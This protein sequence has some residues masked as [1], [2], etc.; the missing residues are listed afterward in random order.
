M[1]A[2]IDPLVAIG[3]EI[4]KQK[5]AADAALARATDAEIKARSQDTKLQ[6]AATDKDGV[7]VTFTPL[8]EDTDFTAEAIQK[9]SA[10]AAEAR[11][12]NLKLIKAEGSKKRLEGAIQEVAKYSKRSE[13]AKKASDLIAHCGTLDS[14]INEIKK[15]LDESRKS[16][17]EEVESEEIEIAREILANMPPRI[18]RENNLDLQWQC[19]QAQIH[20]E[21]AVDRLSQDKRH[22]ANLENESLIELY[23]EISDEDV[24]YTNLIRTAKKTKELSEMSVASTRIAYQQALTEVIKART[25]A[26]DLPGSQPAPLMLS[27][28]P[29]PPEPVGTISKVLATDLAKQSKRKAQKDFLEAANLSI[30]QLKST[31]LQK[32]F[33][34]FPNLDPKIARELARLGACL[35]VAGEIKEQIEGSFTFVRKS[36][37]YNALNEQIRNTITEINKNPGPDN[38]KSDQEIIK[39]AIDAFTKLS[40][41]DQQINRTRV[42]P[43]DPM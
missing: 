23:G 34:D 43:V 15:R 36:R 28:G 42:R 27:G 2:T 37:L 20:Y 39:A 40:K 13:R 11:K 25:P 17:P 26:A 14:L 18:V 16:K 22:V 31:D 32:M 9:L 10:E 8:S 33:P 41:P 30:D 7:R 29:T 4:S 21:S 1:A 35:Q 3:N 5:V 24:S 38:L 6:S 19:G 12:N